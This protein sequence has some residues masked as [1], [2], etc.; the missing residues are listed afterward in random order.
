MKT[1]IQ[2]IKTKNI[3]SCGDVASETVQIYKDYKS[4]FYDICQC[5][6]DNTYLRDH[7]DIPKLIK[8]LSIVYKLGKDGFDVEFSSMEEKSE[9][10]F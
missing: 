10:F 2:L 8:L 7:K 1:R 5:S 3:D 9:D 6:E 4:I